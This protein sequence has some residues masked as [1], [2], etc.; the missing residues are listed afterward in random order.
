M[1][2]R[3]AHDVLAQMAWERLPEGVGLEIHLITM[4]N[5]L[6][7]PADYRELWRRAREEFEGMKKP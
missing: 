4:A 5:I 7:D 6:S 2:A 3:R 1:S